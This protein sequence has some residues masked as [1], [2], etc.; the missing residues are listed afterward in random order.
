[1][2]LEVVAIASVAI[3]ALTGIDTVVCIV[4]TPDVVVS[5]ATMDQVITK[6]SIKIVC[7]EALA[8]DFVITSA[9]VDI[10]SFVCSCRFSCVDNVVSTFDITEVKVGIARAGC[11]ITM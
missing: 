2:V 3:R 5:F 8:I 4:I 1:L 10:T 7:A 9:S 11:P 6:A